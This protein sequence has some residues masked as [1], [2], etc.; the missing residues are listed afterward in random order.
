[1][2]GCRLGTWSVSVRHITCLLHTRGTWVRLYI[3]H[4]A[5]RHL[6]ILF[7][8]KL[9]I[10]ADARH[11]VSDWSCLDLTK[12]IFDT[13]GHFWKKGGVTGW[14]FGIMSGSEKLKL[15]TFFLHTHN[16]FHEYKPPGKISSC[17]WKWQ[18]GWKYV[19]FK[20]KKQSVVFAVWY[21][22]PHYSGCV[23]C[24]L[25][26]GQRFSSQRDAARDYT[27]KR[28]ISDVNRDTPARDQRNI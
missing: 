17:T 25:P 2:W 28:S 24:G 4:V 1:M 5:H 15:T 23:R 19:G 13:S 22:L 12:Q 21:F 11:F 8:Q 14:G 3:F 7:L 27:F 9:K 10:G 20:A 26:S 16:H 6:F 18:A